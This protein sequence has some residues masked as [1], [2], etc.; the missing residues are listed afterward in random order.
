MKQT[1]VACKKFNEWIHYLLKVISML[2]ASN[3]ICNIFLMV[4]F[5]HR[6]GSRCFAWQQIFA[7]KIKIMMKVLIKSY[8]E[9]ILVWTLLCL[10]F[11]L[12]PSHPHNF[13]STLR[14][15]ILEII[16]LYVVPLF[17]YIQQHKNNALT[18]AD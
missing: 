14:N 15:T 4:F 13:Y 17:I 6:V 10:S 1:K 2:W 16:S 12:P 9:C 8:N 18:M 5:P 7:R 3:K 11:Y